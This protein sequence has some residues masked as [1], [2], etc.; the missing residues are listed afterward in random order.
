MAKLEDMSKAELVEREKRRLSRARKGG[1][2]SGG[3][4]A[5]RRLSK[6]IRQVGTQ[7]E[8]LGDLY[9]VTNPPVTWVTG[10]NALNAGGELLRD[11]T[12]G[13]T[14][15]LRNPF[16]NTVTQ[17]ARI[18]QDNWGVLTGEQQNFLGAPDTLGARVRGALSGVS[19]NIRSSFTPGGG[20][21]T[22]WGPAIAGPILGRLLRAGLN[23]AAGVVNEV[24]KLGRF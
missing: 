23:G 24:G 10:R 2:G 3:G 11:R 20:I 12:N 7:A 6:T 8:R 22:T 16:N 13:R 17:R 4:K 18:M 21:A 9:G 1:G 5:T 14:I 15:G 19:Y